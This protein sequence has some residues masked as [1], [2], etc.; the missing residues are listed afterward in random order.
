MEFHR[1]STLKRRN[2]ARTL[3]K[4][5]EE[6]VGMRVIQIFVKA[7]ALKNMDTGRDKSDT[8]CILKMKWSAAQTE[9]S[10]V[11]HTEVIQDNLDPNY[12]HS[13]DVIYN[14]GQAVQL[15]FE[16]NDMDADGSI[17]LIGFTETALGALIKS[18]GNEA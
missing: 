18:S 1:A 9:W 12:A 16:I 5:G 13:F 3:T 7:R 11:D 4:N 15:R 6:I 8:Q 2:T 14:F 10:E 17:N